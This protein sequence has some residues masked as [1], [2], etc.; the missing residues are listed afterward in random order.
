MAL[1]MMIVVYKCVVFLGFIEDFSKQGKCLPC[2]PQ[3]CRGYSKKK[4][5]I[6]VVNESLAVI[7]YWNPELLSQISCDWVT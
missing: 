1:V 4:P 2:S 3:F 5:L 6:A 7:G